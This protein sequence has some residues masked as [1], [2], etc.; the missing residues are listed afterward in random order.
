M[1]DDPRV[2]SRP[3]AESAKPYVLVIGISNHFLDDEFGELDQDRDILRS[4]T[5]V[6]LGPVLLGGGPA[7]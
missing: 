3:C 2:R 7:Q 4:G 6:G 1:W 5:P